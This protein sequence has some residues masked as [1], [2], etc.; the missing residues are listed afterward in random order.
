MITLQH[1]W[2]GTV[3]KCWSVP[4]SAVRVTVQC[5]SRRTYLHQVALL[6][7]NTNIF[8]SFQLLLKKSVNGHVPV[9]ECTELTR[10]EPWTVKWAALWKSDSYEQNLRRPLIKSLIMNVTPLCV[11]HKSRLRVFALLL[12]RETV[13]ITAACH[14]NDTSF[15]ALRSFCVRFASCAFAESFLCVGIMDLYFEIWSM[16]HTQRCC[17]FNSNHCVVSWCS[18]D[19]WWFILSLFFGFFQLKIDEIEKHELEAAMSSTDRW[20]V[21]AQHLDDTHCFHVRISTLNSW[22]CL[23]GSLTCGH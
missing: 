20:T 11:E 21:P 1:H 15:S 7:V 22:P 2:G 5:S 18:I 14:A 6:D 23:S 3:Y 4:C 13:I 12:R 17:N 8:L 16:I 10:K 9:Y 19:A